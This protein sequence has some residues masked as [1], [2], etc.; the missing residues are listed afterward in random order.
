VGPIRTLKQ[1]QH[2]TD[3]KIVY[4]LMTDKGDYDGILI[5]SKYYTATDPSSVITGLTEM[6]YV[7]VSRKDRYDPFPNGFISFVRRDPAVKPCTFNKTCSISCH[8]VGVVPEAIHLY[9]VGCFCVIFL[10]MRSVYNMPPMV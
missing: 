8:A 10:N 9:K 2:P 1:I 6:R 4:E 5:F 7:F 3:L